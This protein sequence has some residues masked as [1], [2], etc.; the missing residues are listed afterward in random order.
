[1]P[2]L[3]ILPL[4]HTKNLMKGLEESW[5]GFKFLV[6]KIAPELWKPNKVTEE[7]GTPAT[8]NTIPIFCQPAE[9]RY[10]S[11]HSNFLA[12]I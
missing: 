11:N 2:N 10:Y 7:E 8:H 5:C 1:M 3:L 6:M 4:P 12:K 9:L